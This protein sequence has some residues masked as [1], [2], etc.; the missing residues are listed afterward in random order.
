MLTVQ[1][2]PRDNAAC[3]K[4]QAPYREVRK[5]VYAGVDGYLEINARKW[6]I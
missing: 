4:L 3:C 2:G 6:L 5:V 1:M